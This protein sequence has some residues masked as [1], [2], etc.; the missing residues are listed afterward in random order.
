MPVT[1]KS[2]EL[3]SGIVAVP[4]L[5]SDAKASAQIDTTVIEFDPTNEAKVRRKLDMVLLPMVSLMFLFCFIDKASIGNA[6]LATFETDLGLKGN[7]YNSVN[8]IFYIPLI[9]LDIPAVLLCKKLGPGWFLPCATILFGLISVAGGFVHNYSQLAGVRFSLAVAECGV[10][11]GIS[12]YLSRWYN[13]AELTFRLS[14]YISMASI[15]GAIGGLLASGILRIHSFGSFG[16]G[17]WRSIFV[18][19]GIISILIGLI[20][21]VILP[22]RPETARFLTAEEKTLVIN[23]LKAE[24]LATTVIIDD[25][26]AKKLWKGAAN[27]VTAATAI[28]FLLESITVNGLSFFAPTIV[29]TIFP[30]ATVI[31]QQLLTVPPYILGFLCI[32]TVCYFSWRLQTRQIF[33]IFSSMPIMAGYLIFLVTRNQ[34]ARYTATFLI[35]SSAFTMGPLCHGQAAAN[36]NSDTAR[37]MSIAVTM[38]FGNMGSLISTWA[39]Q[40]WDGPDYHIGNGLNFATSSTMMLIATFTLFWM[41]WDNK[42][43]DSKVVDAEFASLSEKDVQDLEWKHPDFRWKL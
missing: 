11:P 10:M 19:E 29:R 42:K 16:T 24:R 20:A 35:A 36:V 33:I 1:E 30:T 6:R 8:S 22:N 27:P 38:L 39:F 26:N 34:I 32:T 23:R 3:D 7:D 17:S 9:L 37:S 4:V 43:R 18:L 15:A 28:V 40:S 25:M 14:I 21:L 5:T 13:R 41:K 12:Y 31:Q 2:L